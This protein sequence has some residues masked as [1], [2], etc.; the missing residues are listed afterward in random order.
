MDFADL[1][2][3][4]VP[5]LVKNVAY[6]I[7]WTL[8][9]VLLLK[10][11][12]WKLNKQR[13]NLAAA[14]LAEIDRMGWKQFEDYLETLF[15][16]LGYRAD[17]TERFDKGADLIVLRDGVKTAVQVKHRTPKEKVDVQAV[18]AVIGAMRPYGCTRGIVVTNGRYTG[19]AIELAKQNDIELWDREDLTNILLL[20]NNKQDEVR[21]P[22][23]LDWILDHPRRAT[24]GYLPTPVIAPKYVCASCGR[25]VTKGVEKFCLDQPGRF[26]G[27]VYCYEH[28][29]NFPQQS[30]SADGRQV[31]GQQVPTYNVVRDVQVQ[32]DDGLTH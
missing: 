8:A 1:L 24:V 26:G 22:G 3:V 16:R 27:K 5:A 13:R 7:V 10:Y 2:G 30:K 6:L 14:D 31:P 23:V 4:V 29:R 20:I 25:A 11:T 32:D 18:R 28:Q 12:F 21:L 9:G 19:Q 17:Q 15:E